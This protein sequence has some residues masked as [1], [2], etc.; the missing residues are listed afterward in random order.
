MNK[1][2]LSAKAPTKYRLYQKLINNY[3][4]QLLRAK[5]F[6]AN[7]ICEMCAAAGRVRPTEEVHHIIP[8]ENGKDEAEMTRLAY[9]YNNLQSLCRECHA[10]VHAPPEP[11]ARNEAAR[12]FFE[13]FL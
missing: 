3:K 6:R 12:K 7:P 10:K 5:K 13:K 2:F 9:D 11:V 1:A 8:V 4:W